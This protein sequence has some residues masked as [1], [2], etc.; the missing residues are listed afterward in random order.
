MV[1]TCDNEQF[2]NGQGFLNRQLYVRFFLLPLSLPFKGE[3]S[4]RFKELL[5]IFKII[6]T[7]IECDFIEEEQACD[8]CAKSGT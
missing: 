5:V 2:L 1:R 8:K 4:E 6:L 3:M 7:V